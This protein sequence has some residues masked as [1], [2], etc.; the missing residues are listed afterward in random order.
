M[1]KVEE[2]EPLVPRPNEDDRSTHRKKP[3]LMDEYRRKDDLD[4][5]HWH[6]IILYNL[7]A[8]MV[9]FVIALDGNKDANYYSVKPSK[10]FLALRFEQGRKEF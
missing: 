2:G 6:N 9:T 8:L 4:P 1:E 5:N 10:D 7:G 3:R